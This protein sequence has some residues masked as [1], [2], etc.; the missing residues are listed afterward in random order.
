MNW[1]DEYQRKLLSSPEEAARLV[2][3]GD[4]VKLGL[5][6]GMPAPLC[7]ALGER[8]DELEN[9]TIDATLNFL[10]QFPWYQHEYR[11][12]FRILSGH[13]RDID[14]PFHDMKGVEFYSLS[15]GHYVQQMVERTELSQ[16]PD[17]Y[18]VRVTPPDDDGYCCFGPTIWTSVFY[19]RNM[20]ARTIIAQV[21]DTLPHAY[22][23]TRIHVSQI[24]WFVEVRQPEAEV[25]LYPASEEERLAIEVIGEL[26]ASLIKDRDCIVTGA[27]G[28]SNRTLVFLE[29]RQDLGYHSEVMPGALLKPLEAGIFTGKYKITNPGKAVA[30]A[31]LGT[32]EEQASLAR[33][34]SIEFY[35]VEYTDD[36]KIIATNDNV[37]AINNAVGIDLSGQVCSEAIGPRQY[38]GTG[39]QLDFHLAGLMSKGGR[40]ITVLPATYRTKDGTLKS[41]IV[42]TFEPG[43]P[44][45]VP[46]SLADWV[47]TEYEMVNLMGKTMKERADCLIS[48]AHPDF[49]AELRKEFQKLPWW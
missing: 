31:F 11:K 24:D 25:K 8:K 22:G 17:V 43:T 5:G 42:P 13:I 48:L 1:K 2:K 6:L 9:V 30:T 37:V 19:T 46:R 18:M 3:S 32:K 44:V 35:G 36:S 15:F 27:G 20:R 7:I 16:P 45:T 28:V 39:G 23:D 49:R 38:T 29:N 33:N 47:I 4:K 26:V 40:S 10:Y 21:D 34:P 12:A 41:R 14:R